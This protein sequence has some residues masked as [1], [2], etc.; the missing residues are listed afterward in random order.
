MRKLLFLLILTLFLPDGAAQAVDEK[1]FVLYSFDGR[2]SLV[3]KNRA[4]EADADMPL[5]AQDLIRVEVGAYADLSLHYVVGMRLYETAQCRVLGLA[6]SGMRFDLT[7]GNS[8][9]NIRKMP[10]NYVF[11]LDT[12]LASAIVRETLLTQFTC[13]LKKDSKGKNVVAYVVKK[14]AIDVKT[15]GATMR[16]IEN[17]TLEVVEDGFLPSQRNATEEELT[18]V[19]QA[20]QVYITQPERE[21]SPEL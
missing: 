19:Y 16:L 14:G 7:R 9:I 18:T 13:R 3:R 17:Q 21:D 12:P 6:A 1:N 8:V 4:I 11:Q 20:Q 5:Q 2:V 15:S 10:L